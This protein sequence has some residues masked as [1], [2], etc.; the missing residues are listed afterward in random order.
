MELCIDIIRSTFEWLDLISF[1]CKKCHQT[2][3]NSSLARAAG[4]CCDKEFSIHECKIRKKLGIIAY[5]SEIFVSLHP[6]K[7][8]LVADATTM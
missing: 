6:D 5:L 7:G 4:R 3:G 8:N 1:Q 2:S